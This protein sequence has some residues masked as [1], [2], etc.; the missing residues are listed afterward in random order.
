MNRVVKQNQG[1]TLI[2]LMLSMSFLAILL[3]AIAMTIIQIG[4]IYNKGIVVK[5]IN[6]AGRAIGDDIRRTSSAAQGVNL[7]NDYVSNSGGGRFCLGSFSYIWNTT[8]AIEQNNTN[9]TTYEGSTIVDKPL[10]F[11]KVPDGP[12]NYCAKTSGGALLYEEIR[13]L[14]IPQA[15]EL[16]PAGEHSLGIN[17][18]TIPAAN[19]IND[20]TIDQTIYTVN[21]TLGSG[22][23]KTMTTN[24]SACLDASQAES[25]LAYCSVSAF[26]V[27]LRIGSES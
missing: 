10:R 15:Q 25:D 12:K 26:S 11:V 18:F 8:L 4:T 6:Q 24:Q 27:V 21:Y 13:S 1:F 17:Q 14:D 5:E 9:L 3:L 19:M 22:L 16:L 23:T 20:T 7:A 2:E